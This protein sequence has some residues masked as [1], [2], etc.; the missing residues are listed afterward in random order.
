[1]ARGD[2]GVKRERAE[3]GACK[4]TP[5]KIRQAVTTWQWSILLG[6]SWALLWSLLLCGHSRDGQPFSVGLTAWL[7][8]LGAGGILGGQ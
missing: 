1:M 3:F 4:K 5:P 7:C 6:Q 8:C 2:E